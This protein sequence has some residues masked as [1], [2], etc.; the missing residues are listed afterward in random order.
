MAGRRR[1]TRAQNPHI[2]ARVLLGLG[3]GG[4]VVYVALEGF[5]KRISVEARPEG[6]EGV[7]GEGFPK[8]ISVEARPEGGE[9]V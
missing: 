9:G 6:G 8:R 7:E 4:Y 2:N 1:K 5:P 3:L